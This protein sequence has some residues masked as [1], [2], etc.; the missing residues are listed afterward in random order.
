MAVAGNLADSVV[1]DLQPVLAYR[2]VLKLV[3]VGEYLDSKSKEVRGI[4]IGVTVIRRI[5]E[6]RSCHR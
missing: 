6:S 5:P 2:S 1:R 4:L 3:V